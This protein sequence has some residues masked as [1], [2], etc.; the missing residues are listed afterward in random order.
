MFFSRQI[1]G[2][3]RDTKIGNKFPGAGC[4]TKDKDFVIAR[5]LGYS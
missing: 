2:N 1:P 4:F 5:S 3:N